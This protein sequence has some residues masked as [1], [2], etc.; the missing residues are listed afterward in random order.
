MRPKATVYVVLDVE[1]RE[2]VSADM[3]PVEDEMLSAIERGLKG[4]NFD[5]ANSGRGSAWRI[6]D[7]TAREA[8]VYNG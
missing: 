8:Q 2:P 5:V 4:V 7:I 6:T 3:V 1:A